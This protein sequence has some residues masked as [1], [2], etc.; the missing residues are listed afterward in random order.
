MPILCRA[1]QKDKETKQEQHKE[2]EGKA[3]DE[4]GLPCINNK[5]SG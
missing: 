4:G 2:E 1:V 3:S 5:T